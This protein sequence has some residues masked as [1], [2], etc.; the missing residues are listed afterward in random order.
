M[1][2]VKRPIPELF[3]LVPKVPLALKY[4][5]KMYPFPCR[6]TTVLATALADCVYPSNVPAL[7][8][9]VPLTSTV[10]IEAR[11]CAAVWSA[12][13]PVSIPA[14]LLLAVLL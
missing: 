9:E 5:P 7:I 14:S 1:V 4:T 11:I 8:P 6:L 2:P 10:L 13:A 12:V 3:A